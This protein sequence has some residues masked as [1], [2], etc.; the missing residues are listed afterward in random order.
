MQDNW[1][2]A[3]ISASALHKIISVV[4]WASDASIPIPH[5]PQTTATYDVF[6]WGVNDPSCSD[7][8]INKENFD[9]LASPLGWHVLPYKNDPE[10]TGMRSTEFYRNTTTC[11]GNN[12]HDLLIIDILTYSFSRQV[13]AQENWEGRNEFIDIY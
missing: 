4:D 9:A 13:F 12:V 1:Y 3:A 8:S 6:A 11:W 5:E 7:R 10:S 2:E